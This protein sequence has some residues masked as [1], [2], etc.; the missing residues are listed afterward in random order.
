MKTIG[1]LQPS[2]IPWIGYFDQINKCD[3]FVLYDDVQYDKNGWRNRN[4]IK[5]ANGPVWLT[6]PVLTK[7]KP[8]QKLCDIKIDN[9]YNWREKHIKTIKMAYA[10]APFAEDYIPEFEQILQEDWELLIDVNLA[11]LNLLL[12]WLNINT[13]I[14]LSSRQHIEGEK[15][16]KILRF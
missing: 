12:A 3:V 8:D 6:I 2:Y 10:K 7:G 11:V 15:S 1:I 5:T 13:P 14:H 9:K 16:E 4:K